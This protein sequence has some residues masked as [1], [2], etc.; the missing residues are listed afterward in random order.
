MEQWWTMKEGE[1][2]TEKK[3]GKVGC[4]CYFTF[5]QGQSNI[6]R[7]SNG[8]TCTACSICQFYIK[9]V[10]WKGHIFKTLARGSKLVFCLGATMKEICFYS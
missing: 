9:I 4:C 3:A 10:A 6:C 8:L 5:S 1:W 2:H 7:E